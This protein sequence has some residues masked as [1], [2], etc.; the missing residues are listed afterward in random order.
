VK[1]SHTIRP[2]FDDPNV[3]SDAGVVPAL[4]RGVSAGLYDLLEEALAAGSPNATAKTICVAGG[5]LAGA[6]SIDDLGTRVEV[7]RGGPG[8]PLAGEE[9][10]RKF[11]DN[12]VRS[13]PEERAA[14]I[15]ARTL[16]LPDAQSAGDLTALL[17]SAGER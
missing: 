17:T 4:R 16:A 14:E 8:N 11:R 1:L 15:A 9:L 6:G 12:A 2:A 13:L 3:V 7:S 10:A 5:M